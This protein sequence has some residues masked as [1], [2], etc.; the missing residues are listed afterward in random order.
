MCTYTQFSFHKKMIFLFFLVG[1]IICIT[2]I[3]IVVKVSKKKRQNTDSLDKNLDNVNV[4]DNSR[5]RKLIRPDNDYDD[6]EQVEKMVRER[7]RVVFTT[8]SIP[9]RMNDLPRLLRNLLKLTV[10]PDAIYVNIP[11]YS[12]REQCEYEIPNELDKL[13]QNHSSVVII[14]RCED[15]GPATKIF[16]TLLKETDPTTCIFPVDDDIEFPTRYFEELL[17]Y[18]ISYPQVVFGY[19]GLFLNYNGSNFSF[20][21]EYEGY[22][23]VVET[24]TGAVYRRGMFEPTELL[25]DMKPFNNDCENEKNPCFFTD[26]IVLNAHVSSRGYKRYLLMS[27][28]D[29]IH[30]RGRKGMPM[31]HHLDSSNPLWRINM[32][33]TGQGNGNNTK[34]AMKLIEKFRTTLF[35]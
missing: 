31:K 26:D 12:H 4:N 29:Q 20:A 35:V 16:P 13:V 24:V 22:V 32:D 23:D 30:T 9:S 28:K 17:S 15:Y 5:T 33:F 6:N 27:E 8:T 7:P 19:H 1:L 3:V 21:Q 18:S 25:P 14:N 11:H 10:I 34:C 2:I